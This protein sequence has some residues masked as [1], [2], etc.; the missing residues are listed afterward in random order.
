MITQERLKELYEYRDGAFF[1]KSTGQ[2]HKPT[3]ITKHHRYHRLV[4]DKKAYAVHRLVFLYH[5]GY[6]PKVVDHADNDRAN[7]KIENLRETTQQMNCL[8]RVTHKN[9]KSG[10]KNVFWNKVTNKWC[11]LLTVNRERKTIGYF[12]DFE[13]AELV[14]DE[15]RQK[16]HGAFA[17]R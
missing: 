9:N 2:E 1:W 6:F 8:N 16:F 17:R 5:H 7:N 4:V 12:E 14:A 10:C 3:P 15:A 13:F 11:V